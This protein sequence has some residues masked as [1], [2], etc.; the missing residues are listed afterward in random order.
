MLYRFGGRVVE[1]YDTLPFLFLLPL[2]LITNAIPPPY[3]PFI[4]ISD[5]FVIKSLS[6]DGIG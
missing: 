6:Q 3:L 4:I 2:F 5:N 1:C